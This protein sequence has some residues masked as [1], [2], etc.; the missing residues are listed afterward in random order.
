MPKDEQKKK[1]GRSPDRGDACCLANMRT[2]KQEIY[3]EMVRATSEY[4]RYGE[5]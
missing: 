1:L 4:D 2:I 5:I 3:E